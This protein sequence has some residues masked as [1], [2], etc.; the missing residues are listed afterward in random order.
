[1]FWLSGE[2]AVFTLDVTRLNLVSV[3]LF[4]AALF[5]LRKYKPSPILVMFGSGVIGGLLYLIL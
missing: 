5:F 1:L 4:A 2:K 3:G